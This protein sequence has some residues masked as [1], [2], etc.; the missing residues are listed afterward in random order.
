MNAMPALMREVDD[1]IARGTSTRRADHLRQVTDLFLRDAPALTDEQV[2]LFDVVIA[3]LAAAI[4]ARARV[5]LAERLADAPNAPRGVI[6]SLAHDEIAVARPVLA[7]SER[8]SDEDLVAVAIAKGR[9]HMLAISARTT[10]SEPVTDV[11]VKRGDRRVVHAVAANPGA[12]FSDGAIGDLIDRARIDTPLHDVLSERVDLPEEHV[13][14]LVAIAQETARRR[15]A[16]DAPSE[17]AIVTEVIEIG[18]SSVR[19]AVLPGGRDLA[20]A[21]A[22]VSRLA[23]TRPITEGDVATYA[24]DGKGEEA[25]CAISFAAD[26]TLSTAE[27]LF[28]AG[29]SE[30]L[31]V[32]ARAQ[33]W[34]FTT[35]EPLLAL[36]DPEGACAPHVLKRSRDAFEQLRPQT[37][38]RV[39]QFLKAREASQKRAAEAAAQRQ[40]A[41]RRR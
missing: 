36:R 14:Q 32:V 26:L 33:G 39:V 13:R 8:L 12:R 2:D 34:S 15:L 17:G 21:Y 41:A 25:I 9:E 18:A 19:A 27:R 4:E 30:L 35:V 23:A 29:D 28:K 3:R 37:A 31:V 5:E 20:A 24:R 11:L 22:V 1:A 7:R 38:Q 6:R 16:E 10:L 40:I